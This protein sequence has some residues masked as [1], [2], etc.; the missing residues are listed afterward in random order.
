MNP[1]TILCA[2]WSKVAAKRAVWAAV[3]SAQP[4]VRR[5]HRTNWTVASLMEEA[6][7]QADS[8]PVLAA[9]DVPLG[10]PDGYLAAINGSG[11]LGAA[12]SFIDLLTWTTSVPRFF[13]RVTDPQDWTLCR[14][15]FVVPPGQGSRSSFDDA[16]R[17]AGVPTF[18]RHI[19]AQTKP[20]RF[21][22]PPGFPAR[23]AAR[24][25]TCGW[26][27]DEDRTAAVLRG[28]A[29][30]RRPRPPHRHQGTLWRTST[31]APP[32]QPRSATARS[33]IVDA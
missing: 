27:Y 17:R 14:P 11:A 10:V 31:L 18:L 20:S 29:I 24:H 7:R 22:S 30:R 26:R 15:F 21:S 16:A 32:T 13:D 5:V 8:G 12:P 28:V 23:S 25:A 6:E 3:V 2:D 33:R 19:D 4:V 9:V 1:T